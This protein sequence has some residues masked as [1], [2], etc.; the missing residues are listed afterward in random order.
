MPPCDPLA[1]IEK[2]Y[3]VFPLR[4]KQPLTPH[5]FKDATTDPQVVAA[6]ERS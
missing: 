1:F 4:G 2:G 5:G 3:S 6:W